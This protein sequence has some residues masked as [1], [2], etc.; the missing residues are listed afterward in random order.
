MDEILWKLFKET[1]NI[2]YYLLKQKIEKRSDKSENHKCKGD[3]SFRDK[4]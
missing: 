4:L 3:L 2:N 1:G